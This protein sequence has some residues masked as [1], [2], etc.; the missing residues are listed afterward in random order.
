MASSSSEP[1]PESLI[2]LAGILVTEQS[3]EATLSEVAALACAA[4][5]GSHMAGVT[6][7][8]PEGPT[9]VAAT[10]ET[11]RRVDAIQYQVGAGPCLNTCIDRASIGWIQPA[12]INGGPN[13]ARSSSSRGAIGSVLAVGRGRRGCLR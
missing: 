3:L 6:L 12:P 2:A 4:V 8:G 5:P 7:L 11:A 13:S 1:T 10:D 9:T